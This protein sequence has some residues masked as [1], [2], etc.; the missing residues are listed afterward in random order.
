MDVLDVM[1]SSYTDTYKFTLLPVILCPYSLQV[2]P[3][4][5]NPQKETLKGV[6]F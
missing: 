4:H 1:S 2:Q 3:N 5:A 6:K